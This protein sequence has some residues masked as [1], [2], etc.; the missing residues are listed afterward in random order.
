MV[1]QGQPG[2]LPGEMEQTPRGPVIKPTSG[3]VLDVA[4]KIFDRTTLILN[5]NTLIMSA[6]KERTGASLVNISDTLVFLA[7]G[8]DAA[9][10]HGIPLYPNGGAFEMGKD[11]LRKG[12]I[13]G[14]S[15]VTDKIIC[16]TEWESR[17][18]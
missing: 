7:I 3:P 12:A 5:T 15:S 6:N 13:F 2:I 8:V 4:E 16:A 17:Y 14:I 11:T 9:L 1:L 18:D 10:N